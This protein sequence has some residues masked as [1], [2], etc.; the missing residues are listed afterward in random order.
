MQGPVLLFLRHLELA[1]R[2]H[3]AVPALDVGDAYAHACAAI[4]AS[5]PGVEPE[6][7]LAIAYIE[8]RFDSTATSRVEGTQRK[9]GHYAGFAPPDR[10]NPHASL[11][12]GPLQT[13]AS[14]WQECLSQRDLSTA[15][16][17]AVSELETWLRDRRVHG[18]VTRALAGHGCG[19]YGV[20]TGKCN[21][22]P[23]R[24]LGIEH[25]F[26]VRRASSA[27]VQARVLPRS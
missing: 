20:T 14:T 18:D 24:V 9:T 27:R 12:C 22:Y 8:S 26:S 3:S 16:A 13:F 23:S 25:R 10:L 6:L 4:E 1:L 5:S 7:L 17:A 19:N 21:E 11:Y 15:Y 2:L